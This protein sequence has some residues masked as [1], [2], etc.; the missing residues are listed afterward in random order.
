MASPGDELE[1]LLSFIEF[2]ILVSE[3]EV[4]DWSLVAADHMLHDIHLQLRVDFFPVCKKLFL[5]AC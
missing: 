5:Q 3:L 2:V 4:L 1:L